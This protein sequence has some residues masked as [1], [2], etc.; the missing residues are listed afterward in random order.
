LG[1][2]QSASQTGFKTV[3]LASLSTAPSKYFKPLLPRLAEPHL[4]LA[5]YTANQL[6]TKPSALSE[7]GE[8][9]M[10]EDT[11]PRMPSPPSHF[12][13][14]G[15]SAWSYCDG[16]ESRTN[17]ISP[18][19]PSYEVS[20][21]EGYLDSEFWSPVDHP[22]NLDVERFDAIDDI[23]H[24]SVNFD[25]QINSRV[26]IPADDGMWP[27]DYIAGREPC[28]MD[29]TSFIPPYESTELHDSISRSNWSSDAYGEDSE[30]CQ[31]VIYYGSGSTLSPIDLGSEDRQTQLDDNFNPEHE[32]VS[33]RDLEFY[34]GVIHH[35]WQGHSLLYGL[36]TPGDPSS[37]H[38][39]SNVEADV[40]RQLQLNHWQP[41]KL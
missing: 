13:H 36:S 35:F 6:D 22:A 18:A 37:L 9:S 5:C 41:Q 10:I 33:S 31:G 2:S 17:L 25:G 4:A 11:I 26:V 34:P 23:D 3:D 27:L 29:H 19:Q 28:E 20:V 15:P 40:A 12:L 21:Y 7:L 39:L 32:G 1:P 8:L 30:K 38:K 14:S 24:V 16:Q